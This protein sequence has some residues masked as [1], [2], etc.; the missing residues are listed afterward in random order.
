[1][2]FF[3]KHN[4]TSGGNHEVNMTPLI[5]VSLVLVVMLLLT[6]PLAFESKIDVRQAAQA[7][8]RAK[9][10]ER[11]PR[12]EIVLMSDSTVLVNR[13]AIMR[14]DL[15]GTLRPLIDASEDR[16]V[17]ISCRDGVTHGAFV[18]VLDQAKLCGA[19]EIAVV[20]R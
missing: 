16:G 17:V 8:K 2:R 3:R 14:A 18:N 13:T 9:E 4:A 10:R 6:T 5:D 1:L 20:E 11:D 7:A 12:V 19:G 15:S